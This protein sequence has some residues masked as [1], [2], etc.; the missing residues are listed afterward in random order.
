MS[1]EPT[2]PRV[3]AIRG[4]VAIVAF[5]VAGE[6]LARVA[7]VPLP[8]PVIGMVLFFVALVAMRDRASH[9]ERGAALLLRH[10]SFFFVPAGVGVI[11]QLDVFRAEWRP[12]VVALVAST[13]LGLIAAAGAFALTAR[14]TSRDRA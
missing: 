14:A 13:W 4:L 8:G 6:V 1:V 2:G 12:I 5:D 9:V 7:D 3:G 11:T 10:M